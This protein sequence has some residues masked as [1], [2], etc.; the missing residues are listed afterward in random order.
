MEK[1]NCSMYDY[2]LEQNKKYM[3]YTALTFGNLK[4]TY[5]ELHQRIDEYARALYKKGIRKGD[6]ICVSAANTPETVYILYALNRIGAII[7]PLMAMQNEYKMKQDLELIKPKM[8]ISIKDYLT[9]TLAINR[10][11]LKTQ[12]NLFINHLFITQYNN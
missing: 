4:I 8:I 3:D 2:M 1:P 6:L 9:N 7:V 12:L 11:K 5:E 10:K